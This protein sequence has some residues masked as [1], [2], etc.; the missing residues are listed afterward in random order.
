[1]SLPP[2]LIQAASEENRQGLLTTLAP[3]GRE[4]I[5]VEDAPALLAELLG[6]QYQEGVA[7]LVMDCGSDDIEFYPQ[8]NRIL[9]DAA[10][11]QL[12]V[13]WLANG[14]GSDHY[15]LYRDLLDAIEVLP[16][17]CT[18][19]TL[20]ELAARCLDQDERRRMLQTLHAG[21]DWELTLKEGLLG[22]GTDGRIWY[23]NRAAAQLLRMPVQRLT[24]MYWQSLM[25]MPAISLSP[26]P[27][28]ALA[29]A[30]E[31]HSAIDVKSCPL[32]RG[33][34]SRLPAQ[35]AVVPVD[36][37]EIRMLFA[38]KRVAESGVDHEQ[39]AAAATDLLTGLPTR[40][41]LEQA[42]AAALKREGA[43]PALLVMDID[44][45]RHINETL[46]Y[47]IGDQL[48]QVAARRLRDV[49]QGDGLLA[50]IAG[51]RFV[52]M[53]ERVADFREA[54]RLAQR[55]NG[56]FRQPFLLAGHEIFC[57]LT[58]GVSLYPGSGDSPETLLQSAE[59]ALD[60]AK[61]IGRNTV[62][63]Y[64]AELNRHSLEQLERETALH[65]LLA[66][67][68]LPLRYEPWRR[69][70][71]EVAALSVGL[72][73]QPPR[74]FGKSAEDIAEESGLACTLGRRLV[75]AA[76][77]ASG[78]PRPFPPSLRLMF[79]LP[80]NCLRDPKSLGH[81]KVLLAR[82]GWDAR[83]IELNLSLGEDWQWLEEPLTE[84]G[85]WGVQLGLCLGRHG[86]ALEPL[87]RLPW[88]A[89]VLDPLLTAQV[90]HDRRVAEAAASMAEFGHRLHLEVMAAGVETEAQA[91]FLFSRGVDA[92]S[93]RALAEPVAAAV[94]PQWLGQEGS[95][96]VPD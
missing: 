90:L 18:P 77:S 17:P 45:L 51:D 1:M 61:T 5:T 50:R 62:Q 69:Q 82:H 40:M 14:L 41:V 70:G 15:R 34:G 59:V 30:L 63:F 35:A 83:R 55:L 6:R 29:L 85:K 21:A 31:E 66:S 12:P 25:E 43:S 58:V 38:F 13:I 2:I 32:W 93:G 16:K 39:I 28:P 36:A 56:Q 8:L 57:G 9:A 20:R 94:M 46:G 4:I 68:E 71:G 72:A 33:D 64:S 87:C 81:L 84:L 54:G 86:P 53:V 3:L 47:D 78:W 19:D 73:W 60:R 10:S 24:R 22:L 79:A 65:R 88:Q 76:L 27:L 7:L 95:R 80:A 23:A 42:L 96:N 67:S 49:M 44:H 26:K 37:G 89:L 91:E 92:C 75:H 11:A 52:A 74:Q 48:L